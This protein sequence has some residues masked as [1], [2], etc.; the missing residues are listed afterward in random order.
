M[1]WK[2]IECCRTFVNIFLTWK[3]KW[4]SDESIKFLAASNKSLISALNYISTKLRVQ[5]D[6]RCLGQNRLIF[7]HKKVVNFYIVYETKLWRF[8]IVDK[9][10]VF[11]NYLIEAVKLSRNA[12]CDK[13]KYSAYHNEFDSRRSF[14]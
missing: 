7:N 2:V 12:N 3:P 14:L 1:A 8:N 5:R 11:K 6:G 4:L 10:F 13:F 9:D